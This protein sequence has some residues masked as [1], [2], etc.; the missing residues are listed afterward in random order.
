MY[1]LNTFFLILLTPS[2]PLHDKN[3]K[4]LKMEKVAKKPYQVNVTVKPCRVWVAN[5]KIFL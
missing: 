2:R 4:N 5:L 1:K 3:K